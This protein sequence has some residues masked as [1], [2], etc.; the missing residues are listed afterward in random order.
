MQGLHHLKLQQADITQ[1]RM[2]RAAQHHIAHVHAPRL[3]GAVMCERA[4]TSARG[5]CG[6]CAHT[7]HCPHTLHQLF[8]QRLQ[9][10]HDLG[11]GG[12]LLNLGAGAAKDETT[13]RRRAVGVERQAALVADVVDHLQCAGQSAGQ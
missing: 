6:G 7:S 10:C 1:Q 9:L 5:K 8:L 12:A 4:H 11:E 3:A 2:E 13:Q